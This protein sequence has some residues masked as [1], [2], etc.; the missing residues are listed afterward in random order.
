LLAASLVLI[1]LEKGTHR[2]ARGGW[3]SWIRS[4]EVPPN[5]PWSPHD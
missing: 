1:G 5:I 2:Q 3:L 4:P